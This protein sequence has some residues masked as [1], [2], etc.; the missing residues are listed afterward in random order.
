MAEALSLAT[1]AMDASHRLQTDSMAMIVRCERRL[2]ELTREF[3]PSRGTQSRAFGVP[4]RLTRK[5]VLHDNGIS[6]SRAR[7]AEA[8]AAPPAEVFERVL[9][10]ID[11]PTTRSVCIGLG[12]GSSD[13]EVR[14]RHAKLL[15]LAEDAVAF[16]RT[17]S[18]R[19]RF[20]IQAEAR[21]FAN[22]LALLKAGDYK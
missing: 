2:G 16:I 13:P 4:P 6:A 11:K 3:R 19:R 1:R 22:R 9:G 8:L 10:A 21:S 7:Q 20:P 14:T 18:D 17:C 15:G 5:Q 12:R